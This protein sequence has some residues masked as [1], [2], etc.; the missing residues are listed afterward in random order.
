VLAVVS[1]DLRGPLGTVQLSAATLMSQLATDHRARRHLEM[2]HRSCMRMENLIDDLLDTASI[3]EGRLQL[4]IQREPVASV[5]AEALDLQQAVAAE[6][7][8]H[9]VGGCALP[10][11]EIL[12]D[13][14]RMLQVFGN[15]IGNSLKFCRPGD[16]VTV[17]CTQAGEHVV[18]SV[19][20]TGPGIQDQ[21]LPYLF[22]PYWSGSE[23]VKRG[24][25]LGLYISRGIVESH[26]GR[27]WVDSAPGAGSK[28]QFTIPI[29]T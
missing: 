23:H 27:I 1:H 13:R 14:D 24:A 10:D 21:V 22:D 11:V 20:D 28:F 6:H 16:T 18:F 25:G 8:I 12:C 15:L 29:A 26:G 5:L 2:I 17:A 3:R 9:L 19:T 4:E 7:G